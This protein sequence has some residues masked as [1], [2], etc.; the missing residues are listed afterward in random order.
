MDIERIR[1]DLAAGCTW[2]EAFW[3]QGLKG[4]YSALRRKAIRRG[5][6]RPPNGLDVDGVRARLAQGATRR[7]LARELGVPRST[8][9]DFIKRHGIGI[10]PAV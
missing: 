1:S 4:D 5:L 6:A 3:H 9:E 2:K 10:P 7:G 8:L